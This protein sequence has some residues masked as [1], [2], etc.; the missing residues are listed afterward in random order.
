MLGF[1]K[2]LPEVHYS[3]LLDPEQRHPLMWLSL[4]S[5]KSPNRAPNGHTAM[6]I[7][8][9]PSYSLNNF[10]GPDD[11]IV[12]DALDYLEWLY[13]KDWRETEVREVKRWKYSQP[14]SV[15]LFETVNDPKSRLVIA[16]AGVLAGRVE[17]AYY[18]GLKAAVHLAGQS[19]AEAA[20]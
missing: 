11:R 10:G 16:G 4:E 3:A 6:V 13:G 20:I 8:M 15:A 14:D 1:A 7:Q 2:S 12:E 17:N 18:S 9:S 5:V 19:S